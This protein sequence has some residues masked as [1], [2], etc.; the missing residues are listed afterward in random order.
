M[1]VPFEPIN[2]LFKLTEAILVR[3]NN[4]KKVS[5]K[6]VLK[7]SPVEKLQ[8][9]N[10]VPVSEKGFIILSQH[11]FSLLCEAGDMVQVNKERVVHPYESV[12]DHLFFEL[13]QISGTVHFTIPCKI[14]VCAVTIRLAHYYLIDL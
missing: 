12:F 10:F 9:L 13:F 3:I 2:H 5:K 1:D 6:P 11:Y 4:N 7:L 8:E 14:K